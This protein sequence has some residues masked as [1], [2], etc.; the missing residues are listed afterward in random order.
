MGGVLTIAKTYR[1]VS[2]FALNLLIGD[3]QIHIK[4]REDK[5]I[6]RQIQHIKNSKNTGIS[7]SLIFLQKSD[8]GI[9][10]QFFGKHLMKQTDAKLIFLPTVHR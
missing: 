1:T 2:T 7:S 9:Y 10:N 3:L 6:R 4:I 5:K 8:Y